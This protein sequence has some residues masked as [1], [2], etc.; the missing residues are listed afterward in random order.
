L[1]RVAKPERAAT[2]GPGG[3]APTA[4]GTRYGLVADKRVLY[5]C[6]LDGGVLGG[7]CHDFICAVGA[8][9]PVEMPYLSGNLRERFVSLCVY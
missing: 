1:A 3:H 6:Q 7:L 2:Y 5:L 8:R 4:N 9:L